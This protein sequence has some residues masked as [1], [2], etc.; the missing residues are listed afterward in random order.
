M[1][2]INHNCQKNTNQLLKWSVLM[3]VLGSA[4]LINSASA[5]TFY[6]W[7]DKSGSTHYTQTPPPRNLAK[8]AKTVQVDSAPPP[9]SYANNVNA[10]TADANN[11]NNPNTASGLN[12]TQL[13]QAANSGAVPNAQPHPSVQNN[14]AETN[15]RVPTSQPVQR[16]APAPVIQPITPPPA[17]R[18]IQPSQ[19][20]VRPAFS[21][22]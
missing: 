6:K 18:L 21:D 5:D 2:T 4:V 15:N 19:S 17:N 10:N 7:V 9:Q 14:I 22:Q 1:L 8:K 13:A 11:P 12:A 16:S 3:A 20:Q